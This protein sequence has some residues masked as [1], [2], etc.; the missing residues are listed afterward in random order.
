[1]TKEYFIE[2]LTSLDAKIKAI[3]DEQATVSSEYANYLSQ[4]LM[5]KGISY[6]TKVKITYKSWCGN[7]LSGGGF[8]DK[9][10]IIGK[11]E[12]YHFKQVKKDGTMSQRDL[13]VSG[14]ILNIE[15]I[16]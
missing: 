2:R 4:E 8:F 15:P 1:M 5:K 13:Y 10:S 7:I 12:K 11:T 9:V 6:G 14:Q 16:K 3:K